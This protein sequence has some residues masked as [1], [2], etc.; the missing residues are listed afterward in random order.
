MGD[1][2]VVLLLFF[3]AWKP[4]RGACSGSGASPC[5]ATGVQIA[6]S[7]GLMAALG[8]WLGWPLARVVLMGFVISL[9]STAGCF[10]ELPARHR[11]H[12]VTPRTRRAE[13]SAGA[14]SPAGA[15]AADRRLDGRRPDDRDTLLLQAPARCWPPRC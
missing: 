14:G 3:V 15:D 4:R 5:S 13:H 11:P 6:G 10:F 9:S 7:V 8:W 2:G 1:L 12:A